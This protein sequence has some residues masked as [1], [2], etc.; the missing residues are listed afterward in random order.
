MTSLS[1]RPRRSGRPSA[2]LGLGLAITALVLV[3]CSS[4]AAADPTPND[5]TAPAPVTT[6]T[7]VVTPVPAP[8]DG[9]FDAMPM[10]VDLENATGADIEIDIV[11]RTGTVIDAVSGTPGDG[12]SVEPYTLVVENLDDRTLRLTWVDLPID[13]DLA[14]FVDETSHG[15]RFVLVQ[16]EPT[17]PADAMAFDRILDLTFEAPVSA[18]EVEAILQDGLDTPG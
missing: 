10:T 12:A 9:G 2:A 15:L 6:P 7:P 14:L 16:P 13:N 5:P 4:A 11:D 18:D 8:S 3:A 1:P 17:E